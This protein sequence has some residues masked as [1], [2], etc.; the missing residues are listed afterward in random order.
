MDELEALQAAFQEMQAV[1]NDRL[2]ERCCIDLLLR[3]Q[4]EKMITLIYT[5]DGKEYVTPAHLRTEIQRELVRAGGR[6]SVVDLQPILNVDLSH[7]EKHLS[8]VLKKDSSIHL[9]GTTL[10]S[11]AYVDVCCEELQSTLEQAGKLSIGTLST[12][13]DLPPDFLLTAITARLGSLV[14]GRLYSPTAGAESFLY[15]ETYLRRV[16]ARVRGAFSAL[17]RPIS[18][19]SV[20]QQQHMEEE[21]FADE[22]AALL[23]SGRLHGALQENRGANTIFL[24]QV[25]VHARDH[26]IDSFAAANSF[27]P[28]DHLRSQFQLSNPERTLSRRIPGGLPLSTCYATPAL[29]DSLDAAVGAALTSATWLQISP[30]LPSSLSDAD[31]AQLL[32]HCAALNDAIQTTTQSLRKSGQSKRGEDA[33]QRAHELTMPPLLIE[34]EYLISG[35]LLRKVMEAVSQGVRTVIAQDPLLF[36]AAHQQLRHS[37]DAASSPHVESRSE[38]QAQRKKQR[39]KKKRGKAA[40]REVANVFMRVFCC[41]VCGFCLDG[42]HLVCVGSSLLARALLLLSC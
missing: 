3:L 24:P 10:I 11:N 42:F 28:Y 8:Q 31:I 20:A 6:I 36:Q 39:N 9:V 15:T 37:L 40:S 7:I 23:C 18:L 25:F 29:L 34:D 14:H 27:V 16:R 38:K 12:R 32:Q 5:T 41:S 4:K 2:S 17:T 19:L 13:F 1:V 33:E 35:T 26:Y 22:L 21:L 30:I